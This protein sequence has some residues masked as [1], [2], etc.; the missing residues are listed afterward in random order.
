MIDAFLAK[1]IQKFMNNARYT[2]KGII[3][4]YDSKTVLMINGKELNENIKLNFQEG[5][6]LRDISK[7]IQV[8]VKMWGHLKTVLKTKCHKNSLIA[9]VFLVKCKCFTCIIS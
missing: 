6:K 2:R 1:E 8:E 5:N 7:I 4:S 3:I 9:L